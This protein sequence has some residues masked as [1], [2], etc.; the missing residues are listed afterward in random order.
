M[1]PERYARQQAIVG[2][3]GQALLAQKRVLIL[4]CGGLGGN[5]I[6]TMIRLGVGSITAQDP[7]RFE[8][9]NLNRQLLSTEPLL[10]ASKA[11]AAAARAKA[12]NPA[13]AFTALAESFSAENGD[14]LV[15]GCDLVLDGLD[16]VPD[17]RRSAPGRTWSW[18]MG[19]FW[20]SWSRWRWC[21]RAPACSMPCTPTPPLG[22]PPRPASPIPPPAAPPS[23][24]PRP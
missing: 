14:R 23:S 10:G 17:R 20:G 5:L 22:S 18:S 13:V 21:R 15:A 24:A 16:N 19:P 9:S 3:D 7:D 6:E 4:G 12:V 11:E 2:Q 8:A 1:I